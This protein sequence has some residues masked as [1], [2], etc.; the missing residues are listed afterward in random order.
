MSLMKKT[1]PSVILLSLS[2]CLALPAAWADE[3]PLSQPLTTSAANHADAV[4]FTPPVPHINA[5]SYVLM[6]AESGAM[7][8]DKDADIKMPPASLTKIMTLYIISQSLKAGQISLDDLVTISP[9][10]WRMK[11][12][13]MFVKVG[14]QVPVK[15]L[16]QGIVVQSGNDACTAMAEYVA[17]TEDAFADL[18]NQTAQKLGMKNSHFLDSTGLPNPDHYT[19]AHDLAILAQ[20]LAQDFPEY[21]GWY[22]QK[23]F[24]YNK[25]KQPNRNRLLWR[26][27]SVDGIKTG[28]TDEAGYCLVSSA[29]R[30][31]MRLIAVLMGAPTDSARSNE[32]EA[33]LNFGFRFFESHQLYAANKPL[34][35]QRV[36]MGQQDNTHFGLQ[37]DL[38][39][40]IPRGTYAQLEANMTLDSKLQAPIKQGQV[41]GNV[42]VSLH[43]KSIVTAPLVALEENPEGGFMHRMMDRIRLLFRG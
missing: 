24:T 15:D 12:S 3:V 42:D 43:G 4:F 27:P 33:L 7:L 39:V 23:W 20:A 17:G 14:S 8:A 19:T 18:M 10:A 31:D 35:E 1:I 11:G 9:K 22:Q 28:H 26:D 34:S 29:K 32:S 37:K 5:K 38:Y 40:T 2:C 6:D 16:I 36:W 25:I 21:Y 13:R 30:S 41:Y